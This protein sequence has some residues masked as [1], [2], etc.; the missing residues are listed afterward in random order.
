MGA[1]HQY[2]RLAW[3]ASSGTNVRALVT[4]ATGLVGSHIVDKLLERGD[5]VR[6]LARPTSDISYLL[7]REVAVVYGD[8]RDA[9]S[10]GMAAAGVEVVY[11]A[12]A[13]V[14]DWGRWQEFADT[15]ITGTENMLAAAAAAGVPRFLHVSTDSVYSLRHMGQVISEDTPLEEKP[16]LWDYYRRSKIE[17][18]RQAWRYH[19]SGRLK[20]S[21]VRPGWIFGPRDRLALPGIIRFLHSRPKAYVGKGD[22]R[23]P[24]VYAGDVAEACILAATAEKAIGQAYNVVSDEVVTQR[25]VVTAVAEATGV[26]PPRWSIPYS[27]AYLFGFLLEALGKLTGRRER[28]TLTR[29]AV[30]TIGLNYQEDTSKAQRDLGWRAKVPMREAIR[31]SVDWLRHR[32]PQLVG[33]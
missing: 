7:E 31:L 4:G 23:L 18:E 24:F 33:G 17:A 16:G 3:Q 10:L 20:V 5:E 11:H 25:D 14:S 21:V 2:S 8:L 12:G 32:E 9:A 30:I 22:N 15:V 29:L 6:A 19:Q 28:P 1:H 26:T 27:L 13:R